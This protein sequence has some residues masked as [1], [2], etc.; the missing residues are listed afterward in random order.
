MNPVSPLPAKQK[1]K[2]EPHQRRVMKGLR[3]RLSGNP[4]RK[5]QETTR[6]SSAK[7]VMPMMHQKNKMILKLSAEKL[8]RMKLSKPLVLKLRTGQDDVYL[9]MQSDL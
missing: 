4:S 6:K 9:Q 8:R 2:L 7:R 3:A 1:L 5:F